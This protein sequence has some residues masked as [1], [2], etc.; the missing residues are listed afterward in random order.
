MHRQVEQSEPV[1]DH[2]HDHLA[3]D[4]EADRGYRAQA[5]VRIIEAVT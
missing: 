3:R 2:G 1:E 4:D 5:R